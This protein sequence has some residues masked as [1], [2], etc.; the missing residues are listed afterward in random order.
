MLQSRLLKRLRALHIPSF[1][2][3]YDYVF[4]DQEGKKELTNFLDVVTTNKTDFFREPRHFDYLVNT[5]LPELLAK[6]SQDAGNTFRFWSSA[7]STGE[8]PYTLAMVLTEFFQQNN[9]FD[10]S[11]LGTDIS[12]RV[13]EHGRNAIYDQEK[14]E[15]VP[16][17]MKRQYLMRSKEKNSRLVRIVP[18]LRHMVSFKHLNLMD[19]DYGI[20]QIMDV[21]F[22]RNVIIYF[23]RPTQE[24]V[25]N[26]L[27][28]QLRPGGYVFMGHSETLNGLNVP[29]TQVAATIYRKL[30]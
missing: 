16:L 18:E 11:I 8:E 27:C 21:I 3:Y 20:N 30:K 13:L 17:A 28:R 4:S 1:E 12:T 29:L 23:D 6:R 14:V 26:K 2:K 15:P 5:A 10:F 22:C 7:S 9:G 25:L 19:D 24:K